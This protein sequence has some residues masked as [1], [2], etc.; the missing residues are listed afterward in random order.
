MNLRWLA[1]IRTASPTPTLPPKCCRCR[2]SPSRFIASQIQKPI[3]FIHAA[4]RLSELIYAVVL[5]LIYKKTKR[6]EVRRSELIYAIIVLDNVKG[7]AI[8]K[9]KN[10]K[11]ASVRRSELIYAVIIFIIVI[12]SSSPSARISACSPSSRAY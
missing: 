7:I 11:R 9:Q 3:I 5:V 10:T 8:Q 6:A 2:P 1:S 4:V 12:K